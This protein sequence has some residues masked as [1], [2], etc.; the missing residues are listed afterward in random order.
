MDARPGDRHLPGF[1]LGDERIPLVTTRFLEDPPG[2]GPVEDLVVV[3]EKEGSLRG[4]GV[5]QGSQH[6]EQ[7]RQQ[8]GRV[9]RVSRSMRN[10]SGVGVLSGSSW[11]R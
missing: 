10:R 5:R 4:S 11:S 9:H 6:R 7:D 1:V 3:G 2:S 8:S